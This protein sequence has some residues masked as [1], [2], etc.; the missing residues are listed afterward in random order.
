M[1][2]SDLPKHGNVWQRVEEIVKDVLN[3]G[4][5]RF[6][7]IWK[8]TLFLVFALLTTEFKHFSYSKKEIEGEELMAEIVAKTKKIREDIA[9]ILYSQVKFYEQNN[10][11]ELEIDQLREQ[12]RSLEKVLK[13]VEHGSV[14][15]KAKKILKRIFD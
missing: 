13:E 10:R 12:V 5:P 3:E 11:Y 4:D 14:G 9:E 7:N 1:C 15:D 8:E 6:T 2:S